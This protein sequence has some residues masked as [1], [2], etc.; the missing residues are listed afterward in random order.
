MR[1]SV[2]CLFRFTEWLFYCLLATECCF[3]SSI[4]Y[5]MVVLV[6]C[7]ALDLT[8]RTFTLGIFAQIVTLSTDPLCFRVVNVHL[9]SLAQNF[10]TFHFFYFY[11]FIIFGLL[12]FVTRLFIF[13]YSSI[14][15]WRMNIFSSF[16][17]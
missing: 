11:V 2:F 1:E 10:S 14:Y 16:F 13:T 12:A 5:R 4:L 17:N 7:I 8:D 9:E 15:I 6:Q 3:F